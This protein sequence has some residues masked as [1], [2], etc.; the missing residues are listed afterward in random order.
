[1]ESGRV[2]HDMIREIDQHTFTSEFF[3]L[4]AE[5]ECGDRFDPDRP[6]HVQ[7]LRD[8]IKQRFASGARFFA[9]YLDDGIP[10]G[11]TA[12]HVDPK[13]EGVPYIG[14]YSEIVAMGVLAKHRRSGHGSR[15]LE[16]SEDHARDQGAYCLYV[17][18]YAGAH[19]TISFYEKNGFVRV[20]TLPD[21]HGPVAEG[22]LH[23]RKLLRGSARSPS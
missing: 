7:W 4:M 3:D 23:L 5:I 21:V 18:T 20:A 16:Y 2:H 17:A 13:L 14:Q 9:S 22:N 15:L 12:I 10:V 19:D 8:R 11:F 1:M 6:G